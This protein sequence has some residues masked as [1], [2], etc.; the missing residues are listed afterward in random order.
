[1]DLSLHYQHILPD[2]AFVINKG[3]AKFR[4][5]SDIPDYQYRSCPF[6]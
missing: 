2:Y 1:M 6:G 4:L 3:F 5:K